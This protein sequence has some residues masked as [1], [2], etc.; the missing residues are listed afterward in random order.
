[1]STYMG[2]SDRRQGIEVLVLPA[3]EDNYIYA[4]VANGCAAVI[5][6]GES[7]PVLRFLR[8]RRVKLTHILATHH[9]HDHI[10]G[11]P[12]I[13][14]ATRCRVVGPND[15]RIPELDEAVGQGDAVQVEGFRLDV[16]AAPGHSHTHIVFHDMKRRLLWAGDVL[17]A[18][19]CGRL[20]DCPPELMWNS[21]QKLA[22]L[23][24]DT[25]V[26]FGHEYT[27]QNL[28]F[29]ASVE[30]GNAD[31]EARQQQV[32]KIRAAEKPTTPTNIGLEKK[33]NP[34]LR[35]ESAVIRRTLNMSG[36]PSLQ[37]F[38]ELRRRKDLF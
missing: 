38:A 23:P 5:D 28:R 1:M 21:L 36:A 29:A 30:P 17:A 27:E 7:A 35:V 4:L 14:S 6:P 24:E 33:T 20:F 9:H 3:L 25:L 10:G 26:F 13:K 31:V 11:I 32:E 2:Y 19:G 37:V 15:P 12:E 22:A 8:Q 18:A 34:F 16:L